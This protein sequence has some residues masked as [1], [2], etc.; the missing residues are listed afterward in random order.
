M[1]T[2]LLI[3]KIIVPIMEILKSI[4]SKS[5]KVRSRPVSSKKTTIYHKSKLLGEIFFKQE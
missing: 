4:T 2:I 3:L 1:E 5:A